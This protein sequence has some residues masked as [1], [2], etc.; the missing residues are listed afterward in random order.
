MQGLS[1]LGRMIIVTVTIKILS[2]FRKLALNSARVGLRAP[3]EY[4]TSL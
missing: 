1:K 3:R 2:M 4:S